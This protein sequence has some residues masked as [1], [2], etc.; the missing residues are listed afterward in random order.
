[1]DSK[2]GLFRRGLQSYRKKRRLADA[3]KLAVKRIVS[4]LEEVP[5]ASKSSEIV[6]ILDIFTSEFP[7]LIPPSKTVN[8]LEHLVELLISNN[9]VEQALI[10][11]NA[12]YPP[13][14]AVPFMELKMKVHHIQ[15][16]K[17]GFMEVE[18]LWEV[19]RMIAYAETAYIVG[20][21]LM[22]SGDEGCLKTSIETFRKWIGVAEEDGRESLAGKMQSMLREAEK[23]LQEA[24]QNAPHGAAQNAPQE[25]T[26]ST[27]HEAT[28]LQEATQDAPHEAAQNASQEATPI[29][30][31]E[32]TQD[33]LKDAIKEAE[34][35]KE[36]LLAEEA[37]RIT[38]KARRVAKEHK[39]SRGKKIL[40][41]EVV[42]K[43]VDEENKGDGRVLEKEEVAEGSRWTLVKERRPWRFQIPLDVS[44]EEL[45]GKSF[46]GY[47]K[48][49]TTQVR[50]SFIVGHSS[51]ITHIQ[52]LVDLCLSH[53]NLVK[54]DQSLM[55]A[56]DS[57]RVLM[58]SEDLSSIGCFFTRKLSEVPSES[59]KSNEA[60]WKAIKKVFWRVFRGIIQ[61]LMHLFV[62]GMSCGHLVFSAFVTL[63]GEG[64]ILPS[65]GKQKQMQDLV[66]LA[67]LMLS[68]IKLA[69][70][71]ATDLSFLPHQ[72]THFLDLI[73]LVNEKYADRLSIPL[74]FLIDHPYFWNRVENINF[75]FNLRKLIKEKPTALD[76]VLLNCMFYPNWWNNL[77]DVYWD[78]YERKRAPNA[79]R[80]KRQIDIVLYFCA[81]YTHINQREYKV[82]RL[83]KRFPDKQIESDLSNF[84]PNF[85]VDMFYCLCLCK[86]LSGDLV[87]ADLMGVSSVYSRRVDEE[88]EPHT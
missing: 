19:H 9:L 62:R 41:D 34:K 5:E 78:V 2:F 48:T 32:A 80:Y 61:A 28:Q 15:G 59:K 79:K 71:D 30:L 4:S 65:M 81:V 37:A 26:P 50:K 85:Y 57:S 47:S 16:N 86:Q 8:K 25:A 68:V 22:E 66:D 70:P 10:L 88:E 24:T 14:F 84:F 18:R 46:L 39:T 40:V 54:I 35:H 38:T 29:A 13:A 20:T 55:V 83:G 87:N 6:S 31:Q 42:K 11:V 60:W 58:T 21:R 44:M 64:R 43:A 45:D 53:E 12:P 33:A 72:L 52:D 56:D 75:T 74:E 36:E 27:P 77:K 3:L 82:A 23:K 51:H 76:I 49:N 67:D 69:R 73:A 7:Q 1:M 17:E 63:K